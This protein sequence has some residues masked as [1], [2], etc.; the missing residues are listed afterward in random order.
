MN[1]LR[2]QLADLLEV[3]EEWTEA[4]RVLMGI[5][6]DSGSRSVIFSRYRIAE[7][8]L[9]SQPAH[10]LMTRSSAY[11]FASSGCYS[12]MKIQFRQKH[13]IIVQR[14]SLIPR[15]IERHSC[16]SNCARHESVT[17][18]VNS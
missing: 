13:I 11:I 15:R 6:L 1:S 5:S 14:C 2:F 8:Q 10:F 17:T 9:A 3:E 4:A 7:T 12:K 16:N 18:H